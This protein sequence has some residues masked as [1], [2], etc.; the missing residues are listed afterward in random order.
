MR[1]DLD[2]IKEEL[3][4]VQNEFYYD[5][6]ICLQGVEITF[7]AWMFAGCHEQ[8]LHRVKFVGCQK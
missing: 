3:E 7:T 4:L 8:R 1:L 5:D 6:Q 2:K